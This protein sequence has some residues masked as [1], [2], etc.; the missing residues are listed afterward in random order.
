MRP[1]DKRDASGRRRISS[2]ARLAGS[3]CSGVIEILLFH[4]A[5][6]AGKRLM[7]H[8]GQVFSRQRSMLESRHIL[9]NVV[10]AEAAAEPLHVKYKNLFKGLQAAMMYKVA[11]RVFRFAGQPIV[12]DLLEGA[13]DERWARTFG[14]KHAKPMQHAVAGALTGVGEV[15]IAPLDVLK[16]KQQTNPGSM[17][18][19]GML[20]LILTKR[21]KLYKGS[22]WTALRNG[23]GS[24][25][26]FGGAAAAKDHIFHLEDYNS[27]TFFPKFRGF[28]SWCR[29]LHFGSKPHGCDQDARAAPQL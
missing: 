29:Q 7:S 3:S 22:M 17:Q 4:P 10:F 23:P 24:F 2:T 5:D 19:R 26:L 20:E 1:E 16:I 8:E 11:Q 9:S 25:A 18:G 12:A 14:Q 15:L 6:T 27:A 13:G 21:M 28:D